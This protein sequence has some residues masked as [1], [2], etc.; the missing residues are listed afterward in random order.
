MKRTMLK[1]SFMWAVIFLLAGC[2]SSAGD[3]ATPPAGQPSGSS[4]TG[5][6]SLVGSEWTATSINGADVTAPTAPTATF[7]ADGTVSGTDGCNQYHGSFKDS[8]GSLEIGPLAS[9]LMACEPQIGDQAAAFTGVM[10]GKS[11]Y[12][13]TG[14]VLTLESTDGTVDPTPSIEFHAA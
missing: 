3:S 14:G 6:T 4:T 5:P 2:G 10:D 9:T 8:N 1:I 11:T 12:T 13:L 7:G